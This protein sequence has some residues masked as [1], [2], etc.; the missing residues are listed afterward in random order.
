MAFLDF[1]KERT[2]AQ[3]PVA[4]TSH[5]QKPEAVR[6]LTAKEM[7][8]RESAQEKANRIAPTPDQEQRAQKIG[9]ELS[10]ATQHREQSAPARPNAPDEGSTNAAQI[11]N[12]NQQDKTQEALSRSEESRV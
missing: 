10:K 6:P 5:Q 4:E 8:T 9:E 3:T 2:Q 1:M 12:Q 7:Y 11:Q